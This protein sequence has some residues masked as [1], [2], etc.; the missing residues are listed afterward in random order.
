[1][2]GVCERGDLRYFRISNAIRISGYDLAA[3]LEAQRAHT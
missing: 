3:F 2:Y 1:V